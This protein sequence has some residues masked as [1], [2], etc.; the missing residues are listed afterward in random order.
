M[1]NAMDQAMDTRIGY[2]IRVKG[3]LGE[4]M[5]CAFP[6][7]EPVFRDGDTVLVGRLA[8]QPALH[9][10]LAQIEGLGLEL[11]EVRRLTEATIHALLV[12]SPA[13]AH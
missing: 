6:E 1:G 9:G 10:V 8:D 11:I 5:L 13:H 3:T 12:P 7:L 2:A 4:T